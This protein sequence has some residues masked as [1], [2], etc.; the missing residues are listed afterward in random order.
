MNLS[1]LLT[2][3]INRPA[4]GVAVRDTAGQ[5]DPL[6]FQK[7]LA[8]G[9]L[10]DQDSGLKTGGPSGFSG[11]LSSV[12]VL[13]TEEGK[14]PVLGEGGVDP[15]V[16]VVIEG[17]ASLPG[18]PSPDSPVIK[19]GDETLEPAKTLET[20]VN[21]EAA[22]ILGAASI[23]GIAVEGQTQIDVSNAGF[24]QTGIQNDVLA[25]AR[26]PVLVADQGLLENVTPNTASMLKDGKVDSAASQFIM[27]E[28]KRTTAVQSK[29][30][31]IDPTIVSTQQTEKTGVDASKVVGV[32]KSSNVQGLVADGDK[33]VSSLLRSEAPAPMSAGVSTVLKEIVTERQ[34]SSTT[35]VVERTVV[36]QLSDGMLK[37]ATKQAGKVVVKLTPE[38][39]G[40]V[41]V[42]LAK[43][44]GLTT[45]RVVVDRSETLDMV[46]ADIRSLER[47]LIDAGVD[48]RSNSI[49]LALRSSAGEM[50]A[51]G[52]GQGAQAN[53]SSAS[54]VP[55]KTNNETMNAPRRIIEGRG[56]ILNISV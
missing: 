51:E 56:S 16:G 20:A 34:I 38:H 32:L 11:I 6:A 5:A 33:P 27:P 53:S 18:Q 42:T 49:S 14:S 13:L 39:L 4:T 9:N 30:P 10:T 15:N 55:G 21:D 7:H 25:S 22:S 24:V 31:A 47:S 50:G 48:L 12:A 26:R 17:E 43:K 52:R 1:A 8:S 23:V 44:N 19:I 36:E 41:E 2:S 46:R 37:V 3:N 28:I 35:S 45:V 54:N 40:Q 29:S